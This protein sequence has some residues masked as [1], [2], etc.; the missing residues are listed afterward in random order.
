[1]KIPW[2]RLGFALAIPAVAGL[3]VFFILRAFEENLLYYYRP[4]QVLTGE[5][6]AQRDFRIAGLVVADS[7]QRDSETLDTFFTLTDTEAEIKVRYTG[8]L[9]DLFGEGQGA[10]AIGRMDADGSFVAREILA[11]HDENYMPPEVADA[12]RKAGYKPN[13]P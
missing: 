5:A 8:L 9:P 1:M 10:I 4:T 3:G 13:A 2:K 12:L 7:L 6:P 11:R